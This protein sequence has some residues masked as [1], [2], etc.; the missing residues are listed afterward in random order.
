[1]SG[2]VYVTDEDLYKWGQCVNSFK[3]I[4]KASFAE[5]LTPYEPGR[6][7]SLGGG[8]I[9]NGVVKEHVHQGSSAD[10]EAL[11]YTAPAEGN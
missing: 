1:M 6:Q 3:L 7:S 4:G 5:V 8:S 9:E 11:M 10:F 2:W